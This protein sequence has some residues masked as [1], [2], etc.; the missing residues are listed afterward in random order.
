[1]G[2]IIVR[3]AEKNDTETVARLVHALLE[4]LG[5]IISFEEVLARAE[6]ILAHETV[7]ALI[8][9]D[10]DAPA[11]VAVLNE[12]HAIYAG[13][14]FGEISELYVRPDMRS[15]GVAVHLIEQAIAEGGKRNWKR[16][17]VGA[18]DQPKWRRTL[19]FYL[20]NGFEE[21]GPRLRF[22]IF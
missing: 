6:T 1:M 3:R 12:C 15:K 9:L 17:E 8:A 4:E 16:L 2:D 7:I 10:G 21:V 20:R 19:D 5:D 11:G 13:G 14:A 22:L 18:P